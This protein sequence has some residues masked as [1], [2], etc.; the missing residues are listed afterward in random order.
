M[1]LYL[2][3]ETRAFTILRCLPYIVHLRQNP[4]EDDIRLPF[5][6]R[7]P[8]GLAATVA[9]CLGKCSKLG[10]IPLE[11]ALVFILRFQ[12]RSTRIIVIPGFDAIHSN[13]RPICSAR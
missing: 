5:S 13:L 12:E 7:F 9:H 4:Y 10:P 6:K 11:L 8:G 2:P 1:R 3:Y